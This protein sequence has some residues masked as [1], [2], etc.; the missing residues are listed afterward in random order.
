[1]SR[2]KQAPRPARRVDNMPAKASAH[3]VRRVVICHVCGGLGDNT[4]MIERTVHTSCTIETLAADALA[5]LP[6]GERRK[7]RLIDLQ[8]ADEGKVAAITRGIL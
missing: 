7:F 8:G 5:K 4:L 1:M 3:S 2:A 6:K